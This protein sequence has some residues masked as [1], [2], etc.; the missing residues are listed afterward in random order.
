VVAGSDTTEDVEGVATSPDRERLLELARA[1][2]RL[3][4]NGAPKLLRAIPILKELIQSGRF[5]TVI[6][7]FLP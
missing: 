3:K 4:G 1:A 7:R 5:L 6:R 2:Q